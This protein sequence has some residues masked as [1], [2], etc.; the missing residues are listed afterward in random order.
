[1]KRTYQYLETKCKCGC[2]D[3]QVKCET[4]GYIS[5]LRHRHNHVCIT[6]ED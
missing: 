3:H 6:K 2:G 5:G 1:M 4:C